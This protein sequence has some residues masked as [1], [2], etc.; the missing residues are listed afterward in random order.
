MSDSDGSTRRDKGTGITLVIGG[1]RAGKSA[2]AE[3]LAARHGTR[4]LYVATAQPLDAEMQERIALHQTRRPTTWTTIEEPL[5]PAAALHGR[6]ADAVLLDCATLLISNVLLAALPAAF[7]RADHAAAEA[8]VH[9]RMDTLLAWQRQTAVPLY[10]VSNEV[11][12]GVVPPSA[13]G[14]A[15]ADTLGRVNQRLAAVAH[16]YLVVAGL[17]LDLRAGVPVFDV[18][19]TQP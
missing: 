7:T 4:V 10:I 19:A 11:G 3:R 18:T 12:M 15:Y 5:D 9:R 2:F 6:T 13:L 16:V 14:R 1:V 17:A 8:E